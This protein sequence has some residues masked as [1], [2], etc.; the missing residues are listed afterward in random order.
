MKEQEGYGMATFPAY[1]KIDMETWPR[2]EHF[3]YYRT[4]VR[5]GYSLTQRMDV[6]GMLAYAHR[7]GRRFYGCFLYA[8]SRTVN[9]MDAMKMM[10]PPEGGAGIWEMVN[11]SFTIFHE[12]DHTFSD[13]W[14]EDQE[15][16]E[17]FYREFVRVTE[18]YGRN[19]GIK[20]RP[21]QPANFFC[22][23][24]A[25]WIDFDGYATWL[26]G[27]EEPSLFPIVTS[28]RYEK[29]NGKVTMPV[30][31]SI[32]HAAADGWHA[33]EFFRILKENFDVFSR[34]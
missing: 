33:G 20:A 22:A 17:D 31:L 14:M 5:C 10:I 4:E 15:N 19:H 12:D 7:T 24:S 27:G 6:T 21:D 3:A 29:E 23:S 34:R 8:V 9:S 32:S 26:A 25:P 28:G 16:F 2:R 13:V 11:P 18:T 30:N 1:R